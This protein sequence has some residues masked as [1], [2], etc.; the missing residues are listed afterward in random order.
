M[1]L[2]FVPIPPDAARKTVAHWLPFIEQIARRARAKPL[3]LIGNV[4]SGT[5]HLCLAWD[6]DRN[7]AKAL[8]GTQIVRRGDTRIA[9]LIWLTGSGHEHWIPLFS[10]L[11][12]YFR[13]HQGCAGIK[14]I[15]RPG[16]SKLLKAR[17]YRLTHVMMEKDF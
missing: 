11:E 8:A 5:V 1:K 9:E 4:L 14:A 15:A 3:V 12:R 2:K 13:E 6:A 17:G 7:E 10:D 16:W